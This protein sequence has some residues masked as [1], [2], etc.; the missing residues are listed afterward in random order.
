MRNLRRSIKVLARKTPGPLRRFVKRFF[1]PQFVLRD[2]YRDPRVPKLRR[3]MLA[4]FGQAS[5]ERLEELKFNLSSA[6]LA[7]A[8]WALAYRY[9]LNGDYERA[10]DQLLIRRLTNPRVLGDKRQIVVE[11][12]ILLELGRVEA[13]ASVL[14]R[15]IMRLGEVPDLCF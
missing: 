1:V 15:A 10:L 6:D 7:D 2:L 3:A 9:R 8:A 12:E 13:A 14:D 11:I 5:A 4:G